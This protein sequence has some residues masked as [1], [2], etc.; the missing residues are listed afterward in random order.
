[1]F[2]EKRVEFSQTVALLS[3][4]LTNFIFELLSLFLCIIIVEII[5]YFYCFLRDCYD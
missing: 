4:A 3:Q 5:T 1:M 2:L